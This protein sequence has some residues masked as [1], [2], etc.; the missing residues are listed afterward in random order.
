MSGQQTTIALLLQAMIG[1]GTIMV[2][3]RVGVKAAS[4]SLRT[5]F[6]ERLRLA[7]ELA[8]SPHATVREVGVFLLEHLATPEIA[9]EA[10]ADTVRAI[11][12]ALSA[13]TFD[14][15]DPFAGEGASSGAGVARFFRRLFARTS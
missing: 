12:T 3:W 2:A 8:T 15:I 5:V 4:S 13:G 9:T 6:S 10:E 7:I 11:L 1:F 14:D